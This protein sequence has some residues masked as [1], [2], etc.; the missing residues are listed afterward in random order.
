MNDLKS[1]LLT[2]V[3]EA[4]YTVNPLLALVVA[5]PTVPLI[6]RQVHAFPTTASRRE[7]ALV[8]TLAAVLVV[9]PQVD[10]LVVAAVRPRAAWQLANFRVLAA[11]MAPS[12]PL[13]LVEEAASSS[14]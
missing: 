1:T 7:L 9:R 3:A 13:L 2:I 4:I 8:P 14:K 10:A 5:A 6:K 12:V 11:F